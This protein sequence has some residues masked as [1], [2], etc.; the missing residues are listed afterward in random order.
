VSRGVCRTLKAI[1]VEAKIYFLL[2]WLPVLCIISDQVLLD[3][4]S[5]LRYAIKD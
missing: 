3:K 2:L 5:T 4:L 1:R